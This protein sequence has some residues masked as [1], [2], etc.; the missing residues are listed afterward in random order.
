MSNKLLLAALCAGL[1]LA[2]CGKR[3]KNNSA[4]SGPALKKTDA[5]AL[6]KAEEIQEVQGASFKTTQG[7]EH[8]DGRMRIA[9]CYFGTDPS[10]RSVSLAVTQRD[11]ASAE[12]N[13]VKDFWSQTFGRAGK[14]KMG[15]G[16]EEK[17]E[18]LREQPRGGEEG[19][20]SSAPKKVEG[21]GEE[22]YWIGNRVGGALYV[23]K[24]GAI[25]RISLGGPDKE[26]D[27]IDKTKKL[28]QKALERL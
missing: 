16:E 25:I 22:A 11:P 6:I 12:H 26:E 18:S 19:E 20:R 8:T 3:T 4:D 14:E 23:L 27:K 1:A 10:N 17:R 5:C 13:A 28:A 9:Q 15:E 7:N 21:L 2:G 24:N